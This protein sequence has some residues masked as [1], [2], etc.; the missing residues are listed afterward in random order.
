MN[1]NL[2]ELLELKNYIN[3]LIEMILIENPYNLNAMGMKHVSDYNKPNSKF[4]Q[5]HP[6]KNYYHEKPTDRGDKILRPLKKPYPQMVDIIST[7]KPN[8]PVDI[9]KDKIDKYNIQKSELN[10]VP[11]AK[12]N[13]SVS[14]EIKEWRNNLQNK[15]ENQENLMNKKL[16]LTKQKDTFDA[17]N[18]SLIPEKRKLKV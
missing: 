13:V 12:S 8:T 10:K 7:K 1:K 14:S 2:N 15:I 9:M 17:L 18:Q 6:V 16:E 5:S 11:S 4:N 3:Y